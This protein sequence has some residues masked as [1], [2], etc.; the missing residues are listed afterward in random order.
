MRS[1][2]VHSKDKEI[3]V[4]RYQ[5]RFSQHGNSINALSSGIKSRQA[6]RFAVH[7]QLGDLAGKKILDVGCGF[8][9][10]YQYI[11]ANVTGNIDYTGIDIVPE[12]I[13]ENKKNHPQAQFFCDNIFDSDFLEKNQFDYIFCSQVFNNKFEFTDN[14]SFIKKVIEILQKNARCG[15]AIDFLTSYVD[16]QEPHLFYYPPESLFSFAKS[17]SKRVVLRHDYPLYEFTLFIYP[18]FK[19]WS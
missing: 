1:C 6:I 19:G 16:F 8:A 17:L 3:I 11:S 7:Q 14:V 10:F 18:D 15:V 12:F 9:D 2:S 5:N 13:T 4:K